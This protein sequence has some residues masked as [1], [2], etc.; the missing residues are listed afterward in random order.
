MEILRGNDDTFD[1]PITNENLMQR[2]AQPAPPPSEPVQY[3]QISL[4]RPAPLVPSNGADQF[5]FRLQTPRQENN[6]DYAPSAFRS[7]NQP[8]LSPSSSIS[9]GYVDVTSSNSS[10]AQRRNVRP[11]SPETS[12]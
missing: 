2:Y 9:S 5:D 11:T 6:N 10:Q 3:A 8:P 4:L 7:L 1:P 12:F